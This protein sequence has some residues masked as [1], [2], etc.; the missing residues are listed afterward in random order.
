MPARQRPRPYKRGKTWSVRYRDAEGIERL[1][2]GFTTKSEAGEWIDTKLNE[3]EAL[4]NGDLAT[5]RRREMP[6]L[7]TLVDEYLAQHVCEANTKATL[8]ARLKKAT[9]TFGDVRL[10][11]LAISELRAWR[12]TLPQAPRGTS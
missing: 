6:T 7:Q 3:V 9:G 1:R 2:G 12:S 5:L 8:E 4:R 10:D 11:R